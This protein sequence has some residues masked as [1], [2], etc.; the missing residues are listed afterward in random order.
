MEFPTSPVCP[1]YPSFAELQLFSESLSTCDRAARP[2]L[3]SLAAN[4]SPMSTLTY[5][6]S[7][8]VITMMDD[9]RTSCFTQ[10]FSQKSA[11]INA[12]ISAVLFVARIA[13]GI[14]LLQ[15]FALD[16][17]LPPSGLRHDFSYHII[18][19]KPQPAYFSRREIFRAHPSVKKYNAKRAFVTVP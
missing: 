15:Q 12:C 2:A 13:R 9:G 14:P 10:L 16:R 4:F 11:S 19:V 18:A 3:C 17:R 5:N 6:E 7:T 8:V 1:P